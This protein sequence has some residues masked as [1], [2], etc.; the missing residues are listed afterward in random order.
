MIKPKP[1]VS[2]YKCNK[3]GKPFVSTGLSMRAGP[4]NLFVKGPRFCLNCERRK[5]VNK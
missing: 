3:C 2:I 1:V 4:C 5:N